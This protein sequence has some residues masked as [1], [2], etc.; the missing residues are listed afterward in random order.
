MELNEHTRKITCCFTGHRP[1]KLNTQEAD[2]VSALETEILQAIADGFRIFLVGMARGTDIWAAET[3][4]KLKHTGSPIYLVCAIPFDG[5]E[6]RWSAAWQK[7]YTDV[8]RESDMVRYVCPRYERACFQKRNVWM[9]DR[10]S[11]VIAVYNGH[12]GGT[13]NT[14]VYAKKQGVE[15]RIIDDA[16]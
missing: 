5:F 2:L 6:L 15:C 16:I 12:S 7:R 11:R 14:L 3:V 13:R 1:E 4:V 9:V 8:L 10:S